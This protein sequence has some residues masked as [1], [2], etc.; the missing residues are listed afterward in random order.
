MNTPPVSNSG[1]EII[2]SNWNEQIRF[3]DGL[4]PVIVQDVN[5]GQVL[6]LAWMDE[7]AIRRTLAE[8]RAVYWSRSRREHWRKGDTSGHFQFVHALAYDCDG[9]TLLLTVE[10]VGAACHTGTRSC[11]DGRLIFSDRQGNTVDQ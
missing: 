10:Q 9:D 6:M 3:T 11:F 2:T 8:R 1:E 4:V 7:E 5:N